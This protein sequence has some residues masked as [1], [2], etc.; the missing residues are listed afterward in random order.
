MYEKS[1][2]RDKYAKVR[3]AG[4][5]FLKPYLPP[6]VQST[7][8]APRLSSICPAKKVA[9]YLY[10]EVALEFSKANYRYCWPK[11]PNATVHRPE[12]SAVPL[13]PPS[14][15]PSSARLLY[16]ETYSRNRW[17]VGS[18]LL[19]CSRLFRVEAIPFNSHQAHKIQLING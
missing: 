18:Q 15:D 7:T 5:S 8:F 2:A 16:I 3:I 9:D 10:E 13:F 12:Y 14:L 4:M 1:S 6:L 19:C 11:L 17:S